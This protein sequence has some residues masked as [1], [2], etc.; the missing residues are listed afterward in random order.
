MINITNTII[1]NVDNFISYNSSLIQKYKYH[2]KITKIVFNKNQNKTYFI[3]CRFSLNDNSFHVLKKP[4]Y[5]LYSI[6]PLIS[7][8]LRLLIILQSNHF[9]CKIFW[10]LSKISSILGSQRKISVIIPPSISV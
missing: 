6:E 5:A 9:S 8:F 4:K 3:L 1:N 10:S 2:I 7:T